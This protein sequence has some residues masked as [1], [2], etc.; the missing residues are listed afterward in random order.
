MALIAEITI[1]PAAIPAATFAVC[2]AH[3]RSHHRFHFPLR[4]LGKAPVANP[5][6]AADNCH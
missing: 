4:R 1:E 3:V 2:A 5:R 6:S